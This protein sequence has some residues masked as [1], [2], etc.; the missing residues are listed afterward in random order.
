MVIVVYMYL[1][2][3]FSGCRLAAHRSTVV[4]N[5]WVHYLWY[6]DITMNMIDCKQ[7]YTS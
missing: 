6:L 4:D 7:D 2:E 3:K 5:F 1:L